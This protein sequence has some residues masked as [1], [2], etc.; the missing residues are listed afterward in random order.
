MNESPL[1]VSESP[2]TPV[3]SVTE[4]DPFLSFRDMS[5]PNLQDVMDAETLSHP[6]LIHHHSS[7]LYSYSTNHSADYLS[8]P[9]REEEKCPISRA[10]SVRSTSSV[11]NLKIRHR[12]VKSDWKSIQGHVLSMACDHNGCRTLQQ[13]LTDGPS[14]VAE[15][16]YYEVRNHLWELMVDRFGNY[17]FQ[18]LLEALPSEKKLD[19]VSDLFVYEG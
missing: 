16:V 6:R 4:P 15:E 1:Y 14:N 10:S 5:L 19:L 13:L 18:R 11:E 17:L 12:P 3:E 9:K 7:P 8:F 2:F